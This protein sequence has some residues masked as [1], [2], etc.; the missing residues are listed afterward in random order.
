VKIS[1]AMIV[2][3]AEKT[4]EK[5][6]KS[7]E[8]LVDEIVIVDTGS[9]DKTVSILNKIPNVN[10][11][12]FSWCN[13]FSAARNFSL[14]KTTGD[15][16]LV[17]DDDEFVVNG[18]RSDL[19][20]LMKQNAIGRINQYSKFKRDN[21]DYYSSIYISRFFPRNLRYSGTIHEQII[22]DNPRL[23]MNLTVEHSGYYK[24]NKS[25]RNIPLLIKELERNPE[26]P[27][28]LFQLGQELRIKKQFEKA[29]SFLK[30]SYEKVNVNHPYYEKLVVDLINCGKECGGYEQVLQIIDENK[31]NL[32][33]VSDFHFAKGLFYLD[34]CLNFPVRANKYISNIE[35]SFL[36]SLALNN[37]E[38]IE[39][40]EGTS[41][42]LAAYNLGTFYEVMG[43][44]EKAINYYTFA[45]NYG[46]TLAQDRVIEILNNN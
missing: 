15:Y 27:Y 42:Y 29:L 44:K 3:N 13:D 17:I 30:K 32:Q 8:H 24:T 35:K 25:D 21:Q 26:D 19:E 7:V 18:T 31:G 10:L 14:E 4:I 5:C 34:F 12:H 2:K 46:Y 45:S 37:K 40:L 43:E 6:I 16:I 41:T 36:E 28:Y 20:Q 22:G 11:Y 33:N 23:S 38:H 39:Y 1:L 9:T